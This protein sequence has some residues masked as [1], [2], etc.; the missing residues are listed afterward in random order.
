MGTPVDRP[1]LYDRLP[2]EEAALRAWTRPGR[3][4]DYHESCRQLVRAF[5]PLLARALDRLAEQDR[6]ADPYLD[7]DDPRPG[8]H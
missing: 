5:M 7:P 8:A 4:P 1:G 2:P 6:D 3:H